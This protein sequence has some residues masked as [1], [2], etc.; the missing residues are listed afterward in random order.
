M[1]AGDPVPILI[2]LKGF[3]SGDRKFRKYNELLASTDHSPLETA[4]PLVP[5][6]QLIDRQ[7]YDQVISERARR[8]EYV[9][10]YA[11][12]E[13]VAASITEGVLTFSEAAELLPGLFDGSITSE[14]KVIKDLKLRGKSR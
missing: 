7:K 11:A 12:R 9:C 5:T 10:S 8:K 14:S 2:E 6:Q 4:F 1:R 13:T 3:S